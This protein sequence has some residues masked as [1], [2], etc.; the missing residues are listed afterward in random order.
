MFSTRLFSWR[1]FRLTHFNTA[2]STGDPD[3]SDYAASDASCS[4]GGFSI[5]GGIESASSTGVCIYI[6]PNDLMVLDPNMLTDVEP[7]LVVEFET[8]QCLV[9]L[10]PEL[11]IDEPHRVPNHYPPAPRKIEPILAVIR[12]PLITRKQPIAR[13]GFRR[14]QRR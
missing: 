3:T 8:M 7:D 10:W 12:T 5:V 1:G 11:Y 14:G 9:P 4:R 6:C 2:Y 13:S